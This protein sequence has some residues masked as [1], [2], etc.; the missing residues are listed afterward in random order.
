[1]GELK[2]PAWWGWAGAGLTGLAVL[3]AV[4]GAAGTVFL[5]AKSLRPHDPWHPIVIWAAAPYTGYALLGLLTFRSPVA[6]FALLVATSGV[7]AVALWL[8][9]SVVYHPADALDGLVFFVLPALQ[10]GV[11][12]ATGLVA[13][14]IRLV[15][16]YAL[17][18]PDP[19]TAAR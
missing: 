4:V 17:L 5:G 7:T 18:P 19:G 9:A 10:W 15:E 3:V 11:G 6:S 14:V 12:G 8:Y 2:K 16:H 13:G 1:M